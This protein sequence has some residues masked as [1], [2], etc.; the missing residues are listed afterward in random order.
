MTRYYVFINQQS[1]GFAQTNVRLLFTPSLTASVDFREDERPS[2]LAVA[3]GGQSGVQ[4]CQSL[5]LL[6][7]ALP[8]V[9]CTSFAGAR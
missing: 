4:A 9:V 5:A 3:E 8:P 1:I 2:R 7:F 6:P